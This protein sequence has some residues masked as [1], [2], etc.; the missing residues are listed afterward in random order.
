V[1]DIHEVIGRTRYTTVL[2]LLQIMMEKGI[3][4]RDESVRTHVYRAC[5]TETQT[6]RQLVRDL[7]A[8]AFDGSAAR[9]VM[10]ALATKRAT[11]AELAAIRRLLQ[12]GRLDAVV[13]QC[14]GHS[15]RRHALS[16]ACAR[17]C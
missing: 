6:Q 16:S 1:R 13:S 14:G 2:K 8:R 12:R 4:A 17:R 9:L 3:V 5:R 11:P 15:R 7:L 10:Q